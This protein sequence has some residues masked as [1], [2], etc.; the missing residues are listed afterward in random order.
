LGEKSYGGI[1]AGWPVEIRIIFMA[2]FN[3]IIFIIIK[4]VVSFLPGGMGDMAKNAIK[5][6][7][8]GGPREV[9]QTPVVEGIEPSA[10][11]VVPNP[12]ERGGGLGALFGGGGN[13]GFNLGSLISGNEGFN[14]GSLISGLGGMFGNGN[15]NNA[16]NTNNNNNQRKRAP[17]R[18]AHSD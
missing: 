11:N 9:R 12:P 14:L 15:N 16:N 17:R 13:G 7:M 18:P 4:A 8:K 5:N 3:A 2:V 6:F 1:G 10:D